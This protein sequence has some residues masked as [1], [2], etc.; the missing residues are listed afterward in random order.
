MNVFHP[1]DEAQAA[2]IIAWAAAE[3]QSLEIVAGGSKR[4]L[5]RI[6][7]AD[8]R[9]DMSR[10]A[11]IVDYEPAELI[12]TARA[13]TPMAEIEAQLAANRQ[14]LAFEPPDWRGLFCGGEATGE[15]KGEPT[16]GGVIACNLAGPRRVRAG[17]ARDY[18]LGF[19]AIN[20]WG[21]R[22][23]AGGKVVKNVTGFD[24]CK[25]QAGAY[26]TLS[27]LAEVTLKV[28]PKPE[29]ACTVL[30]RGLA[31]DIAIPELS[32]ALNT[33]YEVS[34][35]AHLPASVARRSGV[36]ALAEGLGAVTALRLE[37]P[38]PSVAFRVKAIE[39]LF[40]HGL[41]LDGAETA[42]LWTEI[43]QVQPLLETSARCVWRL[44]PTPTCAPAVT[45]SLRAQF[46]SAEAFYDWGG[47]LIW[48]SLDADEAG[49]D[50]GAAVVRAA[51][52]R[53]GG[54]STLVVAS[55]AVR[56]VAPVFEPVQ[57]A[58]AAL[59]RR[60]KNGFDPRGVFNPGRMQEAQ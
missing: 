2:E 38:A 57:G 1:S 35:A 15:P 29:T 5:G 17:S 9:F 60:V 19:S 28:M 37:G 22:W 34:A 24:M 21:D 45:N 47:G 27:V 7:R 52:G 23:K 6:P 16:L 36:T 14:M 51:M 11:G 44:C 31:D 42:R 59:S 3:N 12:L 46:S 43:G 26:G 4:R 20:G 53:T 39:S 32:R 55:D 10:L 48:L 58:L 40:G 18:F 33:P 30:L 56:A 13:A 41:R 25:L 8:H 50:G 49:P 54:H